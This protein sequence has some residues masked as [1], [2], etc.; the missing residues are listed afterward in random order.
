MPARSPAETG[1][2][3]NASRP[4]APEHAGEFGPEAYATWRATSLGTIT[5]EIE[6]R[7]ILRLAGELTGRA[8]LDIG[9]GDGDL[10]LTCWRNGASPVIGCDIDPHMI[11]RAA[12]RAVQHNAAIG[13]VVGRGEILPFRDRSFDLVTAITVL[14]F[15]PEP[16]FMIG[17][18]A[19]VL[20]P[21]GRLVIGDLG[22]WSLWAASRRLRSWF[23]AEMWN[24]AK[25]RSAGE[26]RA[27]VRAATFRVEHVSGAIYYPR[28]RLI[29]RMMAPI[30]PLLGELTTFGAAFVA[31]QAS[32]A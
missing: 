14:A 20:R 2:R 4:Q 1:R 5:E 17:E 19:R 27:L 30:D 22:K 23:G 8:V 26:L 6:R 16:A 31:V 18:I 13:Y 9:C 29:A 24:P 32:K 12:L 3:G 7:L 21:G 28:S 15:V 10:T 25:F 11:A